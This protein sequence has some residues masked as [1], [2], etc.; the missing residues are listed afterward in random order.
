MS[1]N[2]ARK[3]DL[4]TE[5]RTSRAVSWPV[6]VTVFFIGNVLMWAD[7][8]NFSVAAASWAKQYGWA[9]SRIGFMLS[10]F[11]LGYL[12]LQPFG[13]LLADK[14]GPRRGLTL[15]LAGS[16]F[17][18]L[19]TPL[20]PT[21][22]WL[23]SLFRVLL[24]ASETAYIPSIV[25]AISRAVP[26]DTQR[27]RYS[28]FMQSGAHMGP[29][30]GVFISGA[31]LSAFSAPAAIFICFGGAGLLMAAIWW[32]YVRRYD[33]PV[34]SQAEAQTPEAL[35]RQRQPVVPYSKLLLSRG[36][37]PLF[38]GYF[39]LPYCQYIFLAWL[40]QYLS[41]YRHMSVSNA[42]FLSA[43]PFVVA[44][45]A[46]NIGGFAMDWFAKMG[47]RKGAFHR[48]SMIGLGAL[49]YVVCTLIAANTNSNTVVIYMISIANAGLAFYV[50]P[51]WTMCT[52]MTPHQG[53]TLSALMN[54]FGIL[55]A[56]ISPFLSGVIAEST[57]AFV[58][59]LELAVS[60]MVVCSL[61]TILFLRV[62]PLS[63][64]VK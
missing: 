56:T 2:T 28:A 35:E 57:G 39:A 6:C 61:T 27:G 44:F 24:G 25:S 21:V 16:S 18:V 37:W 29:A 30:V 17:W 52:D 53:G 43:F 15:S 36:L 41:H 5:R 12:L 9:P 26:A 34:P 4:G 51:F 19:L 40:P 45:V 55:G 1:D 7:R 48:K 10:A 60:V 50:Y 54:F 62:R 8:S 13:G 22:L 63:E 58:A 33:D 64:I 47:W 20:A 14:L 11:S 23:T 3:V 38:A 49:M 59:P 32:L 31:L 46:A 42:S